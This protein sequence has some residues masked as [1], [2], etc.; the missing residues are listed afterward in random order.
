MCLGPSQLFEPTN[1]QANAQGLS[2]L[3]RPLV[4]R[5]VTGGRVSDLALLP[6]PYLRLASGRTGWLA[7]RNCREGERPAR[8]S[9]R[10]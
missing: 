6:D 2:T 4:P 10:S 7:V 5:V 1:A 3:A 8:R 9:G